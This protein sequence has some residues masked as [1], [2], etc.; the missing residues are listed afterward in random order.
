MHRY[1]EF[2]EAVIDLYDGGRQVSPA[3]RR[4]DTRETSPTRASVGND[5][6]ATD[7]DA[8]LRPRAR[9]AGAAP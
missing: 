6:R 8:H 7:L 1:S 4:P 5:L 9:A 3:E 2:L